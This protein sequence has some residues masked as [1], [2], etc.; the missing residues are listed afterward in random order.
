MEK[1]SVVYPSGK[2]KKDIQKVIIEKLSVSLA[3]FRVLVGEKKFDRRIRKT[4]KRLG[5]D[6]IKALPPK[7]KRE[8]KK[9]VLEAIEKKAEV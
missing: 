7:Q 4:V 2:S 3:D 1:T 6:V 9:I 8:K 5:E